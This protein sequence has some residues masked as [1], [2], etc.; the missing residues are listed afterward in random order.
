MM[1]FLAMSYHII[2]FLSID[3]YRIAK[4]TWMEIV[5]FLGIER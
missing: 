1:G 4:S 2:Y 3:L 5:T